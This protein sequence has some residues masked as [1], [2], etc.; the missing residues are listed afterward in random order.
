MKAVL[1]AKIPAHQET[2]KNFRKNHGNTKVGEVTV[3]MV[4]F[5]RYI[6]N[7]LSYNAVYTSAKMFLSLAM[8]HLVKLFFRKSVNFILNRS[9][10]VCEVLKA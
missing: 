7:V 8:L 3:D 1:A 9:M 5:F 2:V 6:Y 4:I 10:V